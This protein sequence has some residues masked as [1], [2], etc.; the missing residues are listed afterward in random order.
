MNDSWIVPATKDR[1]IENAKQIH[2]NL[3]QRLFEAS[4]EIAL[5]LAA[6]NIQRARDHGLAFYVEWRE[7]CDLPKFNTWEDMEK[8][9]SPPNVRKLK[10]VYKS[11]NLVELYPALLLE[12]TLPGWV[13]K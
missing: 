6:L 11:I 1:R 3:I 13:N 4:D 9:I 2:K 12:K 5:D 10:E 7:L 8:A